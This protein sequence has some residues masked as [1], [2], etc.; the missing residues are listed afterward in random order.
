MVLRLR[1]P[2]FA[3]ATGAAI[4]RILSLDAVPDDLAAAVSADRGQ[5]LDRALEAVEDMLSA[6]RDHVEGQIIIVTANFTFS[7]VY[8]SEGHPRSNEFI[9]YLT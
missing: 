8:T 6:R 7:H 4:E 2:G 9:P 3:S 5:F 1:D